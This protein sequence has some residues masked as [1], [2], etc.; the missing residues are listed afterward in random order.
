[1]INRKPLIISASTL[2]GLIL[3]ISFAPAVTLKY[4]AQQQMREM[5]AE[6]ARIESLYLNLWTGYFRAEGVSATAEGKPDLKIGHIETELSY[7]QLWTKRLQINRLILRD[8]E[9]HLYQG[10]RW[11]VGPLLIPEPDPDAKL[12][13]A[14]AT[15]SEWRAGIDGF[16]FNAIH[17]SLSNAD[18]AQ[19]LAIDEASLERLYQWTPQQQSQLSLTGRI[20]DNPFAIST[21]GTPLST[22]PKIELQLRLDQLALGP[23]TR[24]WIDGLKGT[25][26]TDLTLQVEQ[27]G[28]DIR[29]S[30]SGKIWL[31]GF[32]YQ[33]ASLAVSSSEITW[34]GSAEQQFTDATLVQA[35]SDTHL[36]LEQLNLSQAELNLQEQQVSLDGQIEA[37]GL[38]AFSYDGEL[39]TGKAQINLPDL[40]LTNTGR[41]WHG[42]V[43][44]SL[45]DQGLQQLVTD[46][47]LKL[48]QLGLNQPG[49]DLSETAIEVSG[50]TEITP[51]QVDFEGLLQTADAE[52]AL[53]NLQIANQARRW[54]GS[55]KLQLSEQGL[56]QLDTQGSLQLKQLRVSQDDLDLNENQ[57]DLT[58]KL[59]T[60]LKQLSFTG[61]LSTLP[62][63]IKKQHLQLSTA[64]RNWKGELGVDLEAGVVTALNGDINLGL[65]L[66]SHQDGDPLLSLKQLALSNIKVPETNRF[67]ISQ[68]QLDDL[69]IAPEQPLLSLDHLKI[70]D[71]SASA[72]GSSVDTVLLGAIT[73]EVELDSHKQPH[74]WLALIDRLT[75][76]EPDHADAVSPDDT[77][78]ENTPPSE[79]TETASSDATYPFRLSQFSLE[80]PTTIDLTELSATTQKAGKPYHIVINT[81]TLQQLDSTSDQPSAFQFKAKAN[82]LGS[83]NISGDYSPF[84]EL[85]DANWQGKIS[86]MSLPPFSKMMQSQTGYQIESGKLMLDAKGSIRKDQVDS[87]NELVI[88]NFIVAKASKQSSDQFDGQIGMPLST[89]VS[90]LTDSD[91]NLALSIPVKGM[92]SDPEFGVQ[93]AINVVLA[94]VARETTMGYLAVSLLPYSAV[95][96]LGRAAVNAIEGSS[97]AL[98]PVYFEPGSSEI[99][100]QGVDYLSK[101]GNLLVEREALRLKLCGQSVAADRQWLRHAN[102]EELGK[103][104]SQEPGK[105][106]SPEDNKELS[107]EPVEPLSPEEGETLQQLAEARGETVMIY[108]I[109][110]LGMKNE[111]LFSCLAGVDTSLEEKPHV[112]LAL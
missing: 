34:Q 91:D 8:I 82:R 105:E 56:Q 98:D 49:L 73:S 46:G 55:I 62:S 36:R 63:L 83:I 74:R 47:T 61:K 3:I 20:N 109:E 79:P 44:V 6:Q 81:L 53:A 80:R 37:T 101:I 97:I 75:G 33:A 68:L 93:S 27:D 90:L 67:D 96:S 15:P 59:A 13:D 58:G 108:L 32:D 92:L 2:L 7:R 104:P 70:S 86:G 95:L 29:L 43:D 110:K 89:A 69:I 77:A 84:S 16:E 99:T 38:Q 12:A 22:Q 100:E 21:Q 78:I 50:R 31:A 52:I 39:I 102:L 41:S 25:L 60:D 18:M 76:K 48:R 112:K 10:D 64:H 4:L 94:K 23:L 51:Q 17:V 71:I 35:S 19:R 66:V 54:N 107:K 11:Q 45:T 1:M 42:K 5:G 106:P 40:E 85:A 24:P 28:A 26:S 111:Q 14:E 9:L 57:I 65:A 103:E 30:Q 72:E 88:N 87:H